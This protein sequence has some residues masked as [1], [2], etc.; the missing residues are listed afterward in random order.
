MEEETLYDRIGEAD[1]NPNYKDG[2]VYQHTDINNMLSI[3]KTAVNE[4]Y[5]DIQK[6][7][8]GEKTAGNADQLGGAT[9][10]R[11][12]DEELQADDNK[13]PSSQQVKNYADNLFS[14]YSAPV[15]GVDYWTEEDKQEIVD[16]A[17]AEVIDARAGFQTLGERLDNKPYYFDTVEDMKEANLRDGDCAITLGYYNIDDGGDGLYKIT[18]GSADNIFSYE[19]SNGNIAELIN[20]K[21]FNILQIGAK[22]NDPTFDNVNILETIFKSGLNNTTVYIPDGIYYTSSVNRNGDN[23]KT[24]GLNIIG[25]GKPIIKLLHSD[26]VKTILGTYDENYNVTDNI[27]ILDFGN[28]C[29][30]QTITLADGKT[31]YYLA[32]SDKTKIPTYLAANMVLEGNTSHTKAI[33]S[34]I[35]TSDPDGTDTARIYLYETYNETR[36]N[37]YFNNTSNVLNETL[38]IKENLFKDYLYISFSSNTIPSY[39]TVNKQLEQIAT[40]KK[41]RI[42][43]ISLSYNDTNYVRVNCF[44]KQDIFNAPTIYL[45][46]NE[47]FNINEYSNVSYGTFTLNKFSDCI[48]KNIIFDN[49]NLD[50]SQYIDT[51]NA[52]NICITGGTK[53]IN[54]D[55]CKFIN[56]IEGGLQIGGVSNSSA[57]T[58]HD[59]PENVNV[60]NCYFNN[61]GRGDIEIIYGKNITIENCVGTD[62]LD[63]ECNGTEMLDNI[64]INNSNFYACTPYTP[65]VI[66]S[67]C[68]V[69]ISNSKFI[70]LSA[71][72]KVNVNLDNVMICYLQPQKCLLKGTNCYINCF[73]GLHGNEVMY[74]TNTSI[75]GLYQTNPGSAFGNTELHLSNGVIDLALNNINKVYNFK[76]FNLINCILTSSGKKRTISDNK[77]CYNMCNTTLSNMLL[78]GIAANSSNIIPAKFKNCYF[79]SIDNTNSRLIAGTLKVDIINS[80]IETNMDIIA[81]TLHIF[82]SIVSK[83][84]KPVFKAREDIF[85]NGL[86]TDDS[87]GINWNWIKTPLTG[88]KVLFNNVEI[89]DTFE[90]TSLGIAQENQPVNT[91]SVSDSCRCYYVG[92]TDY[93]F[94]KIYYNNG[95]LGIKKISFPA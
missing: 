10:S 13:I 68:M 12:I 83:T 78:S 1:L 85:V 46:D 82:D 28:T 91:D 4:N 44:E 67:N 52:Y 56:S 92:S 90:S 41:A 26:K 21:E 72:N 84:T 43:N 30:I 64:N 33:I 59:Y 73:N 89:A 47:P 58:S 27:G 38:K 3:L 17:S 86:K 14:E 81:G 60:T 15:R 75:Y 11:Y 7:E 76:D 31:F 95:A 70:I 36:K 16:E 63:I 39:I 25:I 54:I 45:D 42:D 40:G 71:Q 93:A 34:D 37:N 69:N 24:N 87:T 20:K 55:N 19:I 66:S 79:K 88:H 77:S 49:N 57:A 80:I 62:T 48:I 74:F 2:Q 8:N 65:G 50:V 9:F 61:N 22:R 23:E 5:H 6:L 18:S 53:N 32:L 51:G 35:D 29:T 94:G